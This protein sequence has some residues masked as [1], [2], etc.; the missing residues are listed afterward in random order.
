[1]ARSASWKTRTTRTR[2]ANSYLR[3]SNARRDS[4]ALSRPS[5]RRATIL[6]RR[7]SSR[8]TR[9]WRRTPLWWM[10]RPRRLPRGKARHLPGSPRLKRP[11]GCWRKCPTPS[12]PNG[13]AIFATSA[14]ACSNCSPARSARN[15]ITRCTP[16]SLPRTSALR[17]LRHWTG[18]ASWV[19][20]QRAAV[21]PR[22]WPYWRGHSA[23][24]PWPAWIPGLSR[25]PTTRS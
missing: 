11:Q 20:A 3:Q 17:T 9:N 6:R 4:S 25:F 22:M 7:R 18:R 8:R 23:S 14:G 10:S 16:S 19:F 21:P 24:Q 12:S 5:F 2:S 15:A 1:M 13:P